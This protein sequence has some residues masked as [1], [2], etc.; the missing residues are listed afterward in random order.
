MQF[1]MGQA[2]TILITKQQR[3]YLASLLAAD[4][5]FADLIR[6]H[7]NIRIGRDE[8]ILDR[9]EVKILDD[10]FGERLAKIGFNVNYKPNEEGV[11]LEGLIVAL[12]P[13]LAY[14]MIDPSGFPTE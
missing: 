2:A 10:Y 9:S 14:S 8:I 3:R 1:A 6:S 13:L 5:S 11:L 7:P 12:F 4:S